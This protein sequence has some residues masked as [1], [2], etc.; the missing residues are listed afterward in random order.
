MGAL[1]A[2]FL[3]HGG[4][5]GAEE[6]EVKGRAEGGPAREAGGGDAVEEAGAADAVGAV[7]DADGGDGVGGEGVGVPHV[8]A[9]GGGGLGYGWFLGWGYG[10]GG[11][12]G[13]EVDFLR[14]GEFR[15]DGVDV[16]VGHCCGWGGGVLLGGGVV[17]RE[18]KG[19]KGER[20]PQCQHT[21]I[22][23]VKREKKRGTPALIP[24]P[25]PIHRPPP[26]C[27]VTGSS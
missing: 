26:T 10:G 25:P 24:I 13:E 20:K 3:A 2:G 5:G 1:G 22:A 8:D 21:I 6:R 27:Q 23:Y 11:R 16:D 9:W 4:A 7:G 14:D 17:L 15:Q 18:G 19:V 12:A